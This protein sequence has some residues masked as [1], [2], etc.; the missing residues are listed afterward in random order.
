M[1]FGVPGL[2]VYFPQHFMLRVSFSPAPECVEADCWNRAFPTPL[3]PAVIIVVVVI[4]VLYFRSIFEFRY[5]YFFR[6]AIFSSL[7]SS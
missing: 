6:K 7:K 3:P 4:V 1:V 2:L 5:F